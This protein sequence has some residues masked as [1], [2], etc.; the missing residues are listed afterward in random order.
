MYLKSLKQYSLIGAFSAMYNL[1]SQQKLKE[2]VDYEIWLLDFLSKTQEKYE[3]GTDIS[4][5]TLTNE[6]PGAHVAIKLTE[7]IGSGAAIE[8][9]NKIMPLTFTASYKILDMIFEWILEENREAGK[10]E[11]IP[12]QFLEKIK[13]IQNSL[14]SYPPLFQSKPYIR[15]YLFALYSSLLKFRNEVVHKNNFSVLDNKLKID[16][17]EDGQSY[18]L[19]LDRGELSALIKTTVAAVN[20]LTGVLLYGPQEERLFKYHLD[21]IQKLHGLSMFKQ[22]KPLLINVILNVPIEKKLFSANLKF[23]RREVKRIHPN[24]DVQ[25]NLKIIGLVNNKPSVSWLFPA[26]DVPETNILELQPDSYKKYRVSL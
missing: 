12:W 14:L 24:T 7:V 19:V 8:V 2:K 9:M 15:D 25:F 18:T 21:R 4:T 22:T 5:I 26:N 6:Q 10:I 11:G 20:L 17:I 3:G 23:V 13:K 16:T 1:D